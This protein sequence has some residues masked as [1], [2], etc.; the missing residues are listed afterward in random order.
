MINLNICI[1]ILVTW[2]G[3]GL[4]KPASGTWGTLFALP[5]AILILNFYGKSALLLASIFVF[6]IGIF[7]SNL[8]IGKNKKLDPKEVVIDEVAGMFISLLAITSINFLQISL[9]F[10][11]FRCFDITKPFPISWVDKNIKS[12]LGIMLDDIIAGIF[13]YLLLRLFNHFYLGYV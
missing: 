8:Y 9:A 12:G 1:K 7:A 2:F 4:L 13:A 6:F 10:I 5:F 3:S 11:F